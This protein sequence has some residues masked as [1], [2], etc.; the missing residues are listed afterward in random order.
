MAFE[1]IAYVD[2]VTR[3]TAKNLNDIQ[4]QALA[5]E[6]AAKDA[7]T[8][9][10]NADDAARA[11][12]NTADNALAAAGAACRVWLLPNSDSSMALY[13]YFFVQYLVGPVAPTKDTVKPGDVLICGVD[14]GVLYVKSLI[15]LGSSTA[16]L[17]TTGVN[18]PTDPI[19]GAA[20]KLKATT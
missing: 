1:K 11:A 20:V 2:G 14:G 18:G 16:V 4:A 10:D 3:I 19:E 9:A 8:T 13:D 5:N 15:D 17:A 6:T 7:Q 12:Q